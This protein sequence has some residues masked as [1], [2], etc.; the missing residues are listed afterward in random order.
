MEPLLDRYYF[1]DELGLVKPDREVFE[2][3]IRDLGVPPRRIA[4]FD[5]TAVNVEAAREAG[6]IAF[7]VDGMAELESQLQGLGVLGSG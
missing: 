4:F 7:E 3:V 2:Y 1:S 5:D 6:M